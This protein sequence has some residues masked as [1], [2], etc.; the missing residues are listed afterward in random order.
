MRPTS[1]IGII[2]LVVIGIIF[3]DVLTHP[4]GT[5]AAASGTATILD[6]TY[7]ALLGTTSSGTAPGGA[8]S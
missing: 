8:G 6:P 2:G 5:Q 7:N 1:F 4:A 3:A